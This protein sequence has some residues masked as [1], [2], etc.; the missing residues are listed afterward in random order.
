MFDETSRYNKV[1]GGESWKL[2]SKFPNFGLIDKN[3]TNLFE[4]GNIVTKNKGRPMTRNG[5]FAMGPYTDGATVKIPGWNVLGAA[6][7]TEELSD[8]PAEHGITRVI[9]V[10]TTANGRGIK[11]DPFTID[12]QKVSVILWKFWMKRASGDHILKFVLTSTVSGNPITADRLV[13][14][15]G[16]PALSDNLSGFAITGTPTWSGGSLTIPSRTKHFLKV[17]QTCVLSGFTSSG[18]D[19]DGSHLVTSLIDDYTFVITCADPGTISVVGTYARTGHEDITDTDN[20]V[21]YE[22]SIEIRRFITGWQTSGAN[23]IFTVDYGHLIENSAAAFVKLWGLADPLWNTTHAIVSTG[24]VGS[25]TITVARPVGAADPVDVSSGDSSLRVD[26]ST[27][28]GTAF[29]GW[30]GMVGSVVAEFRS[31]FT[32]GVN[33]AAENLIGGFVLEPFAG[34]FE[35]GDRYLPGVETFVGQKTYDWPDCVAGG[36]QSTTVTVPG[37]E[38]G[39]SVTFGLSIDDAGLQKSAAVFSTGVATC[40]IRNPTGAGINLAAGCV[41]TA[42]VTHVY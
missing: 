37:A 35:V 1:I 14:A 25:T 7:L 36:T 16:A 10:A 24:G 32:T 2:K 18:T 26:G 9:R 29:Y 13:T 19:P 5:D 34:K 6:V 38:V 15:R 41:I 31:V 27:W 23:V 42:T 30:A 22:G 28:T 21:E 17:N 39:D 33:T 40:V 12:P 11:T 4:T 20:W 3:G 8:L